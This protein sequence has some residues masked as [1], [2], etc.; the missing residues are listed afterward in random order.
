MKLETYNE[1][2]FTDFR[3]LI[4]HSADKYGRRIALRLK[5]QKL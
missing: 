4:N 3:Q 1:P 2:L 5:V